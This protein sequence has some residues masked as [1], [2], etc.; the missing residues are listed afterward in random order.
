MMI[1]F[2]G[3][4]SSRTR[5]RILSA[6]RNAIGAADFLAP[7]LLYAAYAATQKRPMPLF[8]VAPL[9]VVGFALFGAVLAES[10]SR[11][12][13]ILHRTP[14]GARRIDFANQ[15]SLHDIAVT[16]DARTVFAAANVSVIRYDLETDRST[17]TPIVEIFELSPGFKSFAIDD[18]EQTI[19]YTRYRDGKVLLAFFDANTMAFR[20]SRW[21]PLRH[22]GY[23]DNG[24]LIWDTRRGIQAAIYEG[25]IVRLSRGLEGLTHK[26]NIGLCMDTDLDPVRRRLYTVCTEPATGS[27][28]AS[29]ADSLRTVERIALP[30]L[31]QRI[32]LDAKRDRLFVTFPFEG[33]IRVLDLAT[34]TLHETISSVVGVRTNYVA[35]EERLLFAGGIGPFV[36]VFDADTFEL[37][38]R[39]PAPAWQ[40]DIVYIPQ[41]RTLLVSSQSGLYALTLPRTTAYRRLVAKVDPFFLA[42]RVAVPL[43]LKVKNLRIVPDPNHIPLQGVNPVSLRRVEHDELH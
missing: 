17:Q 34:F 39:L 43:V 25:L 16:R 1:V 15:A 24:S 4:R 9:A 22:E 3:E 35:A 36:E 32:S 8:R 18:D 12:T 13:E 11:S 23:V 7:G 19:I 30:R 31:G 28:I 37:V 26:F 2:L 42:L 10:G 41:R 6:S 40:R 27:V 5:R 20:E 33:V 14:P 38:D 29:D 21:F